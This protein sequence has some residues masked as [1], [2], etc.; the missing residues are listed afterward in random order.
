MK[1][2]AITIIGLGL[3]G[4][5]LALALRPHLKHLLVVDKDPETLEAARSLADEVTTDLSRGVRQ[6][7]LIVLATPLRTI[8]QLVGELPR[9]RP[10]GCMVLDLGSTKAEVCQAMD[11]LPSSFQAIGGHPMCGKETSTFAAAT[12]DLYQDQTFVLCRSARTRPEVEAA[13]L[14]MIRLIGARPLF[15]PPSTHD[16]LVAATSHLPYLVAAALMRNVTAMND[17]R[18]WQVSASGL[19]DTTRLSASDPGMILDILLTNRTE[20]LGQLESYQRELEVLIKLMRSEDET[21]LAQWL[22]QVQQQHHVYQQQRRTV[23]AGSG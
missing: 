5:S 15:L 19:R 23:A 20:V 22:A 14:E 12:H 4:G 13:A 1:E 11:G 18:T 17:D 21:G 2:H 8:L 16:S 9:L 7:D 6:A 3:M 10:E